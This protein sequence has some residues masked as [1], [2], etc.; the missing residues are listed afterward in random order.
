MFICGKCSA[1]ASWETRSTVTVACVWLLMEGGGSQPRAFLCNNFNEERLVKIQL[2]SLGGPGRLSL[3]HPETPQ[4]LAATHLP[5]PSPRQ[6]LAGLPPCLPACSAISDSLAPGLRCPWG[7]PA[8]I[9]EWVTFSF[10][11]ASSQPRDQTHISCVS[12]IGRRILYHS[13]TWESASLIQFSPVAQSCP[14]LCHPMNR[15]TPGLPVHHQLPEFT[16]THVHRVRDAI[17]PSH[18]LSSPFPPAPS[19]SQH[20]GLFQ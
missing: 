15:S 10:S 16:Q 1:L 17:Q 11:R 2:C 12:C 5:E 18:P 7:Y 20:Q 14:T 6:P 8:T 3:S 4:S 19:P 13:A 9:E